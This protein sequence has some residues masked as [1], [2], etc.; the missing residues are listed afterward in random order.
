MT[1]LSKIIISNIKKPDS[2]Y[3]LT[4]RSAQDFNHRQAA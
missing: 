4:V 2:P 3:Y 1:K